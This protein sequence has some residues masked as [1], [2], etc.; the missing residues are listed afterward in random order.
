MQERREH[1]KTS[2][3][4]RVVFWLKSVYPQ[5]Q[6]EVTT[7]LQSIDFYLPKH[8]L[9]IEVDGSM[10][11]YSLSSHELSKTVVK[12]RIFK[13]AG[14]NVLRLEHFN[15]RQGGHINYVAIKDAIN[16]A[17]EQCN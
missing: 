17:I 14:L 1:W 8:N 9:C 4:N 12:Y 16:H 11:Y 5:G 3:E 7:G 13:L 10:H 15:L 2:F 6:V